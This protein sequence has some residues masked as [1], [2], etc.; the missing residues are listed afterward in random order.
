MKRVAIWGAA[1][2]GRF[3]ERDIIRFFGKSV[4]IE[5]IVDTNYENISYE[6]I[7][8]RVLNPDA[9]RNTEIDYLII[10]SDRYGEIIKR[11]AEEYSIQDIIVVEHSWPRKDSLF[12]EIKWER[13]TFAPY[14]N[15]NIEE[16]IIIISK[17]DGK[18]NEIGYKYGTDKASIVKE[19]NGF[20]L[21]HN[22][23]KFYEK[24]IKTLDRVPQKVLELGCLGG[25][26]LR[27]WKEYLPGSIV[28]GV[29]I[30]PTINISDEGI[31]VVTG[32]ATEKS[33]K[34]ALEKEGSFDL[35]VDDASHAWGD[36]R[37][38]FVMM[39]DLLSHDGLY[40]MEDI[41]CGA[42]GSFPDYPP[43]QWDSQSIFDFM[44][45]RTRILEYG[46]DWNPEANRHHF[47]FLPP[48]IQ[49]IEME[50]ASVEYINGACI[51]KKR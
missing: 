21:G 10:C 13:L 37:T 34:V 39:W 47:N 16:L 24:S 43:K 38:S 25:A 50:I 36:I 7:S 33:T 23:L 31:R 11:V 1:E 28:V 42:Q 30:D 5:C 41:Y 17:G 18:L 4:H 22:Y 8:G 51:V 29:D 48:Q 44:I 3:V 26:S 6:M 40:I 15:C 35:I 27:T 9:L 20:R 14:G 32:N 46:L 12:P 49:K 2:L 19:K 45:D